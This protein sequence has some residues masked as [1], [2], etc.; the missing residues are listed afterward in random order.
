[1]EPDHSGDRRSRVDSCHVLAW[2]LRQ[3]DVGFELVT[4][5]SLND[6][7]NLSADS[8]E[9]PEPP[10]CLRSDL[11][12]GSA[13]LPGGL[14]ETEGVR[15]ATHE[16]HR[17]A[18]SGALTADNLALVGAS[19]GR[20]A[21]RECPCDSSI[22]GDAGRET[23]QHLAVRVGISKRGRLTWVIVTL[24]ARCSNHNRLTFT[25]GFQAP[26][27]H[28][29]SAAGRVSDSYNILGEYFGTSVRFQ[30]RATF[31]SRVQRTR[32]T[33]TAQATQT[34]LATGVVCQSPR[35]SFRIRR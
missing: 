28:P 30:Q 29:Q 13:I 24:R 8:R 21:G 33:G 14:D 3:Q 25:P 6:A 2:G 35:V 15:R 20:G 23:S 16:P 22:S 27:A 31:S 32:V 10:Q 18:C 7:Q 19:D 1:M 11:R 9:A 4:K 26:F 12:A 34:M 5:T 17:I